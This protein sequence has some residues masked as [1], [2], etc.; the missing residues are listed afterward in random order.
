VKVKF[1]PQNI[2]LEI[3]PNQ[4]VMNLAHDNGIFIKSVCKG[5]PSCAECRVRIV[6]GENNV[7]PPLAPELNLIGTAYFIDRRRL[8]CQLKCFGDVTVD[9]TEQVE[10]QNVSSKKPKGKYR[11]DGESLAVRGNMIDEYEAPSMM[12]KEDP[13]AE[14]SAPDGGVAAGTKPPMQQQQQRQGQPRD[15]DQQ[16]G[17]RGRNRHRHHN[18]RRR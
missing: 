1:V 5:L 7:I 18:N 10:K 15:N 9:L 4:S 12:V 17:G 16:G 13:A 14:T 8:S 6:D 11:V 3:K 2:E